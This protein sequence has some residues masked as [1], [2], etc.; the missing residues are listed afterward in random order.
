MTYIFDVLPLH[1]QPEPW[2]DL[3]SYISRLM[4]ANRVPT[5]KHM[6]T[7]CFPGSSKHLQVYNLEYAAMSLQHLSN[8][9]ACPEHILRQTTCYYLGAKFECLPSH[10]QLARFMES[11]LNET[12]RFCPACIGELPYHSLLWRF[13]VVSACLHHR[14][15]LANR[16]NSCHRPVPLLNP[17]G[18]GRCP[19]CRYDLR[20]CTTAPLKDAEVEYLALLVRDLEYILAP[21]HNKNDWA[22]HLHLVGACIMMQRQRAGLTYGDITPLIDVSP[23]AL[24]AIEHCTIA[25]LSFTD[26]MHY[27][28]YLGLNLA[29]LFTTTQQD[30][31]QPQPTWIPP[32]HHVAP[33][34]P[35]PNDESNT[36]ENTPVFSPR[37][38][39]SITPDPLGV[40]VEQALDLLATEGKRATM[41]DISKLIDIPLESL[42]ANAAVRVAFLRHHASRRRA[43]RRQSYMDILRA[44]QEVVRRLKDQGHP[45]ALTSICKLMNLPLERLMYDPQIRAFIIEV[46]KLQQ[47]CCMIQQYECELLKRVDAAR[48]ELISL[49]KPVTFVELARQVGIA[50]SGLESYPS[51]KAVVVM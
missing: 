4:Y 32:C 46:T 45:I 6:W 10:N 14:C 42:R 3:S 8:L 39:Q 41:S 30:D 5:V 47:Q 17:L 23:W 13:S 28:H 51:I 48:T 34:V 9:A 12:L 29:D 18:I 37:S 31:V 27:A 50:Q 35:P 22:K 19:S 7:L 38:N 44:I 49:E 43:Q 21:Q 16:C 40:A 15:R 11:S 26:Y 2:E 36:K 24:Q 25:Q 33:H 20:Q 1:P